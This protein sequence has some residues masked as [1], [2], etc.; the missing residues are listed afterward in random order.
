[1]KYIQNYKAKYFIGAVLLSL[2]ITICF[3][4]TKQHS[5]LSNNTQNKPTPPSTVD[6]GTI[7]PST[8]DSIRIKDSIRVA[9]S[10]ANANKNNNQRTFIVGTGSGDLKIDGT[11]IYTNGTKITLQNGDIIKIKGGSYNSITLTKITVPDGAPP[12]TIQNSGTVEL[13]NGN[14]PLMVTN[15]NNLIIAGNG[16]P[17]VD[18]GFRFINNP[19]RAV[20]LNGKIN[21]FTIRDMYFEN[22]GDLG[23]IY[24]D[25]GKL[26]YDGSDNSFAQNLKFLN[27]YGNNVH[28]FIVLPGKLSNTDYYGVVKGLEIAGVSIVNSPELSTGVIVC[29]GYDY[30]IHNNYVNNINTAVDNHNGIFFLYGFGK[31][32]NNFVSNHQGNAIRAWLY[33]I[34]NVM[35]TVEIYNNIVFNSRR[36]GAFELQVPETIKQ[37]SLFKPANAKVYNNTAGSLNTGVPKYFEGRLLDLYMLYG[38]TLEIKNN[39]LFNDNDELFINNMSD[40]KIIVN[41][42]NIYKKNTFDAVSDLTNFT[43]KFAGVGA[44]KQNVEVL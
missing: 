10:I 19:Y 3:A 29:N 38:G 7:K 33:S 27:L 2:T 35:G 14:K 31:F 18:K 6:S 20:I 28:T 42:N 13:S 44:V 12:V 8:P 36:Y 17:N 23:I 43:S 39:L 21:N 16:T 5:S 25:L 4:C 26:V 24:E 30:N 41:E 37:L 34:D 40:T 32:Y 1:M 22:I 15:A 9:D 11:N